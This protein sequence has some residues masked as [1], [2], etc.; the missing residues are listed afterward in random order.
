MRPNDSIALILDSSYLEAKYQ[1]FVDFLK[2]PK[3]VVLLRFLNDFRLLCLQSLHSAPKYNS[4]MK[5]AACAL[6]F[7]SN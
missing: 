6:I 4:V 3:S 2:F 7:Q 1:P 5:C